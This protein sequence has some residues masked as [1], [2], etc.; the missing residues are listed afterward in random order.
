MRNK[1][2]C[3]QSGISSCTN[4]SLKFQKTSS[5]LFWAALK[6]VIS[7]GK[8]SQNQNVAG[9]LEK[10]WINLEAEMLL[11]SGMW[12]G[13][14]LAW[15]PILW[16]LMLGWSCNL[17]LS[18]IVLNLG[19]LM[20]LKNSQHQSHQ[21]MMCP[22]LVFWQSQWGWIQD[23]VQSLKPPGQKGIVLTPWLKQQMGCC[24]NLAHEPR[25]NVCDQ[26]TKC[27]ANQ[28]HLAAMGAITP[29][30]VVFC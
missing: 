24:W 21:R 11:T 29:S 7:S 4:T 8:E 17:E 27:F 30:V 26:A 20:S 23:H 5:V 3:I 14:A 9:W 15:H 18:E 12:K 22:V 16:H 13:S 28:V 10:L 6:V 1:L 19:T 25:I 2:F